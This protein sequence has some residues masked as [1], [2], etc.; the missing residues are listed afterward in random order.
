MKK[1]K[2]YVNLPYPSRD[3]GSALVQPLLLLSLF[4]A[5][6][7]LCYAIPFNQSANQSINQ[8]I[9]QSLEEEPGL[10][11]ESLLSLGLRGV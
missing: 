1:K 10:A 2:R 7:M 5:M 8:S 4:H 6:L 11:V 3:V 9:N